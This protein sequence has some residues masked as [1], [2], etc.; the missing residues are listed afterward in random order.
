[1]ITDS[2]M[3]SIKFYSKYGK[4]KLFKYLELIWSMLS[5]SQT[6]AR[7]AAKKIIYFWLLQLVNQAVEL[8]SWARLFKANDIVS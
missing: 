5:F 8:S 3:D 4:V 6:A 1:M 7:E 2:E